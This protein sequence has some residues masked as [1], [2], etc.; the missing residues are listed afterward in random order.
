[1]L[2]MGTLQ[3]DIEIPVVRNLCALKYLQ[4]YEDFKTLISTTINPERINNI[5]FQL[6]HLL[7]AITF[8]DSG[9]GYF[10]DELKREYA[11]ALIKHY[12]LHLITFEEI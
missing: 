2:N 11:H 1:M 6:E 10:S 12:N 4:L 9:S 7:G 3:I 8:L 5:L